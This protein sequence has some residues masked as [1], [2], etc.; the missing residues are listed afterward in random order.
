MVI[1]CF[2][3]RIMCNINVLDAYRENTNSRMCH[4]TAKIQAADEIS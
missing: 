4:Q 2:K 3:H 1:D